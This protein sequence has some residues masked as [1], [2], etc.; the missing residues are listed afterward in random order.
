MNFISCV[1]VKTRKDHYCW[2]CART[3]PKGSLLDKLTHA[4]GREIS[5]AYW[6]ETCRDYWEKFMSGD[7]EIGLGALRSGDPDG[8]EA[9]R[10]ETEGDAVV[11]VPDEEDDI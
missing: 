4:I 9:I 2:G 1:S 3:F 5:S 10:K 8:W 6:C 11:A 7:D